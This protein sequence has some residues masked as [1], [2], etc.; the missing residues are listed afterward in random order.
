MR[1]RGFE[2]PRTQATMLMNT[3]EVRAKS[4]KIPAKR[5]RTNLL[6]IREL[7]LP[8]CGEKHG[9]KK[10]LKMKDEPTIFMKTRSGMDKLSCVQTRF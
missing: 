6:K 1:G 7:L 2:N 10:M 8:G 3:K 9:P 5:Q 4:G